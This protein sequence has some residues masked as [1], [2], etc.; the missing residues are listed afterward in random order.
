M[1][2]LKRKLADIMNDIDVLS[3]KLI[4][5]SVGSL[6]LNDACVFREGRCTC[7]INL[8]NQLNESVGHRY[9]SITF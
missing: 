4:F 2:Y 9:C 1:G 3:V 6:C 7:H 5:K 8:V